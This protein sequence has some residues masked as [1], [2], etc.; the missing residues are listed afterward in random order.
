[1]FSQGKPWFN[2][3]GGAGGGLLTTSEPL[4]LGNSNSGLV[5]W[6]YNKTFDVRNSL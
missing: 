6:K 3:K 4:S 2:S 1:M 5:P